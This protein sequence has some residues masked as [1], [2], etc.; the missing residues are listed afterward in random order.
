MDIICSSKLT[1]SASEQ[2][3]CANV[4]PSIFLRQISGGYRLHTS[5]RVGVFICVEQRDKG[6]C[7]IQNI[8]FVNRNLSKTVGVMYHK[9]DQDSVGSPSFFNSKM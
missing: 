5:R 6:V 2:I 3:M 1:V 8:V 4:Y 9:P 7:H